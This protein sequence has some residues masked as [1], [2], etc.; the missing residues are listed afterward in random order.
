MSKRRVSRDGATHASENA[1]HTERMSQRRASINEATRAS[2]N[3][4]DAERSFPSW[5][6]Q[7]F[8]HNHNSVLMD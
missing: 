3:V 1:A 8:G 2:E 5:I 7:N 4:A 6:F